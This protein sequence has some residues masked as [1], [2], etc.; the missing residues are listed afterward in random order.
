VI[1][2]TF[3]FQQEFKQ[4]VKVDAGVEGAVEFSGSVSSRDVEQ[5]TQTRTHSFVYSR[6]YREVHHLELDLNNTDALRISSSLRD[7]VEGL[8]TDELDW[9]TRYRDFVKTFGTHFT[10]QVVLGGMA[11][12]RTSGSSKTCLISREKE[13]ELQAGAG[14]EIDLVEAGASIADART[15][16]QKTDARLHLERTNLEYRGGMGNPAGIDVRWIES[17]ADSPAPVKAVLEPLDT[18]LTNEFF[19]LDKSIDVKRAYLEM[20]TRTWILENGLPT[21]VTAPLCYGET[22][23]FTIP[24]H[25][26]TR[27]V[28]TGFFVPNGIGI[29]F[30][31]KNN[32]PAYDLPYYK[33]DTAAVSIENLDG[34][35]S[36]NGYPI[37]AGDRI[38]IKNAKTKSVWNFASPG[39]TP[40][41]EFFVIHRNDDP[42][43]PS[44][45]QEY[46]LEGDEVEFYTGRPGAP[47]H[48]M[49]TNPSGRTAQVWTSRTVERPLATP[50]GFRRCDDV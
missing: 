35:R 28:Q 9:Q 11:Y 40:E 49:G 6:A 20:A 26:N 4:S 22:L 3:D 8:P 32:L 16:A 29:A 41:S 44:R 37:L 45:M 10:K 13:H 31:M 19:P 38:R 21:S 47:V 27:I 42:R 50:F 48:G 34:G 39:P 23:E 30:P 14:V 7:A 25:D 24:W 46:F 15:E 18:L 5:Q 1:S 36:R 17:C 33:G 2:S 43:A 12:Q